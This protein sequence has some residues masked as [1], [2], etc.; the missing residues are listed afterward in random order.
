MTPLNQLWL[1]IT[2]CHGLWLLFHQAVLSKNQLVS[3]CHSLLHIGFTCTCVCLGYA[4]GGDCVQILCRH[5]KGECLTV[6]SEEFT[7]DTDNNKW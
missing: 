5:S 1:P 2:S 3:N 6:S 7:F 4:N